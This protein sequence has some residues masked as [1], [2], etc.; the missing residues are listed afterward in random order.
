MDKSKIFHVPSGVGKTIWHNLKTG[1]TDT[2]M[3]SQ[4]DKAWISR[5]GH[6][7]G[8]EIDPHNYLKQTKEIK[9][10]KSTNPA[11]IILEVLPD[12]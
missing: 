12:K 5:W 3:L 10:G 8:I 9:I 1:Q 2:T 6:R 4:E 7:L 11:Y